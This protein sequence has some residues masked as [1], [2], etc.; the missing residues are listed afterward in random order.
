[1]NLAT[2]PDADPTPPQPGLRNRRYADFQPMLRET[3]LPEPA[4]RAW[5]DAVH[6]PQPSKVR[7][8]G[9][10]TRVLD[11][12]LPRAQGRPR[13]MADPCGAAAA[14]SLPAK[15]SPIR[16]VENDG[17]RIAYDVVGEGPLDLVIVW[18]FVSHLDV[19]REYPPAAAFIAN[20]ARFARVISF[21]RR[22]I[23]LSDRVPDAPSLEQRIDD[24]R[25]VMDAVGSKR[26][27]IAGISEGGAAS[28][29]FS[30]SHPDRTRALVLLAAQARV[31]RADDYE[32]GADPGA[33]MEA[34]TELVLP[35]WGEGASV[36]ITAPS[37]SA[38]ED[39]RDYYGRLERSS[40][41]PGMLAQLAA[42]SIGIDVRDVARSIAVPTLVL[43]KTHD[44]LV[45]VR[46]GRWLA[47]NIPGARYVEM[48]G[49]DHSSYWEGSD[50]V[51]DEIGE[52]LTG[53]RP[54]H[55][56]ERILATVLFTDIVDSTATAAALGDKAWRA[57][58]EKQQ[59]TVRA[60]I[61]TAGG[62]EIKSTGDGFL[63]TFDG[64]AKGVRCAQAIIERCADFDIS[65][66]AGLHA[67]ECE[68]MGEDIGGIAVHIAAR[69]SGLAESGEVM[70]SRTVTDLVA[71]SGLEFSDR[72]SH[73]LKGVPN[74][75]Q[76][77]AVAT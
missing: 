62:R 76:L 5:L 15:R 60:E 30:A 49:S 67:G 37:Q 6:L 16:Y 70:V 17:V 29:L 68:L 3:D 4:R 69:V 46:H 10:P 53:M 20:L 26:A 58:L 51:A 34:G 23:G 14:V 18:G 28:I 27:A 65:I 57:L 74:E 71:G 54:R 31:L 45:D 13:R 42:I 12:R 19:N 55:E 43:H 61:A 38:N 2:P 35:Y 22:G 21:D 47:E 33:L 44:L 63:A 72:G 77:F 66:R 32:F 52:F 9:G 48:P 11:P 64:P 36:D 56:P 1:M 8:D 73:R 24:I 7:A 59:A 75:W 39:A 41:S 25:A 40:A 50:E